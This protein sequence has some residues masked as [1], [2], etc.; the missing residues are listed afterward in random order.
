M[1]ISERQTSSGV[2][3]QARSDFRLFLARARQYGDRA[4]TALFL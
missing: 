3:G 1:G 4:A 2:S